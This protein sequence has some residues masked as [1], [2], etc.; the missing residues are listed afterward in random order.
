LV[1]SGT[2]GAV[3]SVVSGVTDLA[4]A[5]TNTNVEAAQK[6]LDSVSNVPALLTTVATGNPDLGAKVGTISD[7]A[8]L[9]AKPQEAL[10]NAAT[11]A[12]A[13]KTGAGVADLVKSAVSTPPPPSAPKPPPPPSCSVAGA[14]K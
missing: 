5:A 1:V 9:A 6:G 7:A 3:S 13:V 4:G 2:I 12:D 11:M 10:K 8:Q 14:C